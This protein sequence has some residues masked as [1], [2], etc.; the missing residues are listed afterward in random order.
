MYVRGVHC[1]SLVYVALG[2]SLCGR[3]CLLCHVR[4]VFL[5]QCCEVNHILQRGGESRTQTKA[6]VISDISEVLKEL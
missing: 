2:C 3:P 5:A 6:Q 4:I 1:L